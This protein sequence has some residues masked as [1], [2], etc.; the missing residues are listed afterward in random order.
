MSS[1]FRILNV[2]WIAKESHKSEDIDSLLQ[3]N[4]GHLAH[5][6][7]SL[8]LMGKVPTIMFV[9][10]GCVLMFY[11]KLLKKKWFVDKHYNKIIEVQEKLSDAD[12]GDDF[13]PSSIAEQYKSD[14]NILLTRF[15]SDLKVG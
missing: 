3:K 9:K 13:E 5:E 6:L 1:D 10:G 7:S 11:I 4:A 2:Y 15:D 14:L 12:F 8:M